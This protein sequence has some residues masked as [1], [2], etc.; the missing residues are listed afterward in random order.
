MKG[1]LTYAIAAVVVI[2]FGVTLASTLKSPRRFDNRISL[3]QTDKIPYGTSVSKTLVQQLFPES[4]FTISGTLPNWNATETNSAVIVVAE[5]FDAVEGE[6]FHMLDYL[7]R[8]NSVLLI[9]KSFSSAAY[10]FFK[11]TPSKFQQLRSSDVGIR[12]KSDRFGD[13]SLY[14]YPGIDYF[15]PLLSYN[16]TITTVLGTDKMGR[17]NFFEMK[18]GAGRLYIH[19][20]PLAFSNYFV[21]HKSNVHYL[22]NVLSVLENPKKI[23]WNESYLVEQQR[24]EPQTGWLAGLLK[25]QPFRWSFFIALA[26]IL[27]Y[28][29]LGSRRMQRMVVVQQAPTNDS[30][31]FVRTLGQLYYEKGNHKNLAEKM[32]GNFLEFVR[33]RYRLS[34]SKL[35]GSFVKGLLQ[36][37]GR[38]DLP[39]EE[40]VVFINSLPNRYLVSEAELHRFYSNLSLIYN[41]H[42]NRQNA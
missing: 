5:L 21:L 6:L 25:H 27:L 36:R 11:F 23:E 30:V 12:L 4:R 32:S 31:E 38:D 26:G 37:A 29:M 34:T 41:N 40:V 8:G 3:R 1:W 28:V 18:K 39:A 7:E 42:Y 16:D 33:S 10:D 19:I 22:E 24:K 9:T 2:I 13:D 15:E 20:A 14:R 17:A 35:D